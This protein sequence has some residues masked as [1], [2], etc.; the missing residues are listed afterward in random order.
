MSDVIRWLYANAVQAITVL[1]AGSAPAVDAPTRTITGL[2]VPFGQLGNAST[3][4]TRINAGAVGV[5]ENVSR[6]KLFRDHRRA[7]G[8]GMVVGHC[9]AIDSTDRGLTATFAIVPGADGDQALVDAQSVRDGLSVELTE[10][11]MDGDTV[12]AGALA[13]VALVPVPAFENARV[14]QVHANAYVGPSTAPARI[15]PV[16]THPVLSLSSVCETLTA[17]ASGRRD[18][19]LIAAFNDITRSSHPWVSQT[20]WLGELWSGV[21]YQREYVPLLNPGKL[22]NWKVQGW[23]WVTKPVVAPYDGDKAAVPTNTPTT[24][25]AETS[26]TRLAG[27][28][29]IDRKFFDFPDQEFLKSYFAAMAESYAMLSDGQALSAITSTAVA[30]G[31][32]ESV[33]KAVTKARF[34]VKAA[35]RTDPTFV[36]LS[37]ADYQSLLD[38]STQDVP[39]FMSALKIDPNNWVSSPT[40]P[41][42]TVYVGAR[43]AITFYELPGAPIRVEAEHL[44]NG[45]RDAALFGYTAHIAHK[46]TGVAKVTIVP[47]VGE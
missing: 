11:V 19:S 25:L 35:V 27:G 22:T 44:A 46:A 37:D 14:T 4:A 31:E 8:S 9:T 17:I 7:D 40:L 34:A 30:A 24:E 6:I 38:I 12:I 39:A 1:T 29:D 18:D 21:A 45:G 10:V 16:V 41:A 33:L 23:R 47:P 26:A 20:G 2:I 13:A 28:H 3:G 5:P 15:S 42:G 36:L 43:Q 32:A